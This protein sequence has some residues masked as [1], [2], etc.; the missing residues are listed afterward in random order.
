M[1]ATAVE[2]SAKNIK[3]RKLNEVTNSHEGAREAAK[4]AKG[5]S[6]AANISIEKENK[7]R[8]KSL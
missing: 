6:A 3:K 2:S 1:P 4:S 5:A 8:G 7:V